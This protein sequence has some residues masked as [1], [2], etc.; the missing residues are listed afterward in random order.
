MT[1]VARAD[2]PP[3]SLVDQAKQAVHE[4]DASL[5]LSN[6]QTVENIVADSIA[7]P[8]FYMLLLAA[9]ASVALVLAAI[10]IF[11]VMSY[12][13][14]RT[15]EIGIRMALGAHGSAVVS[16]VL[17]QAM[18]LAVFGLTLGVAAALA[19]SRTM[20]TLLFDLSPTDPLTFA[21]V[22]TLLALVAL[23]ASY[24][25]ARRAARVDPM[26]ALRAE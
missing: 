24:L 26:I 3:L 22:A 10:G 21:T 16:M 5:P 25:P 8:R 14:S 9:F 6:I 2:V 13:V 12:T 1:V 20:T 19:L 18:W 15:R 4:M 17:R 11:G 23:V 7:Q